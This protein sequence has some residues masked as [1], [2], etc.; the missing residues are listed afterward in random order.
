M[1]G[2]Y[3]NKQQKFPSHI[4]RV[5]HNIIK[6]LKSIFFKMVTYFACEHSAVNIVEQISSQV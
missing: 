5:M 2:V 4:I 3:I 6:Q 1:V